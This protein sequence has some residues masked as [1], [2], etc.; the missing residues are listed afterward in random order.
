MNEWIDPEFDR[1]S[2]PQEG[3]RLDEDRL[4]CGCLGE[5]D[6]YAHDTAW[7]WDGTSDDP[8]Y[9]RCPECD[10]KVYE[11]ESHQCEN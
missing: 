9:T 8:D 11:G 5:C 10:C 4:P 2:A 6:S 1:P 7:D 3:D